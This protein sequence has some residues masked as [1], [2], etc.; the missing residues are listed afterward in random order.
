MECVVG[1]LILP[2]EIR[3]VGRGHGPHL[4]QLPRVTPLLC[5]STSTSPGNLGGR[6]RVSE[7]SRKGGKGRS[8]QY[9]HPLRFRFR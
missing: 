5:F 8:K 1:K 6:L 9:A 2:T 4:D 7:E 3:S